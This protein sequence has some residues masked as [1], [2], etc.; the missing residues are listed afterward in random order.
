[1]TLRSKVTQPFQAVTMDTV[2]P[3]HRSKSGKHYIHVCVDFFS[4][5]LIAWP[6]VSID[7]ATTAKGFYEHVIAVHGVPQKLC[8]DN[9]TSYT[10]QIFREACK[11]FGIVQVFSSSWHPQSQGL[12]ERANQTIIAGLRTFVDKAQDNWDV[13][14]PS[15]AFAYNI[16]DSNTLGYSP[17]R[18][19]YG[20]Q[21]CTPTETQFPKFDSDYQDVKQLA[22]DM[23]QTRAHIWK[24]AGDRSTKI[25]EA[26]KTRWDKRARGYDD[27]N[28]GDLLYLYI[29]YR[30]LPNT[31][32]K[33]QPQYT[34][35]FMITQRPTISTVRIKRLAD[36]VEFNKSVNIQRIKK[37]QATDTNRCV[38]RL[39]VH[40]DVQGSPIDHVLD[41]PLTARDRTLLGVRN[42]RTD[43]T[44]VH[45]V[46]RPGKR[47]RS[48][49]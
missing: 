32:Y 13:Y 29:P 5:Y 26:M 25:H 37:V 23:E 2:G 33:L 20:R 24:K 27:L 15:I 22:T 9:G 41:E 6:S 21:P 49:S 35:P 12:V 18:M 44:K 17:Y 39:L 31:S 43:H 14:L 42:A 28:I 19:L 11:Q 46:S 1:M 30:L 45:K 38:K 47:P 16:S 8:T 3:V 36:G 7:A 4:K 10:G 40:P 34:G 48:T